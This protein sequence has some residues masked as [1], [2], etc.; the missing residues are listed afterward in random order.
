MA[1]WLQSYSVKVAIWLLHMF[2]FKWFFFYFNLLYNPFFFLFSPFFLYKKK[3]RTMLFFRLK[4]SETYKT[5][6]NIVCVITLRFIFH[7]H[8]LFS[9][10]PSM[11]NNNNSNMRYRFFFF[12]HDK[13]IKHTSS[14]WTLCIAKFSFFF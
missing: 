12:S 1:L 2:Y 13:E 5:Y 11:L 14:Y 9:I 8:V 4:N 6:I 3:I 10:F 7:F